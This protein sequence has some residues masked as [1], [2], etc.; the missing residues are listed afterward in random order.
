MKSQLKRDQAVRLVRQATEL[1]L[2]WL[3]DNGAKLLRSSI[4]IVQTGDSLDAGSQVDW[5]K[6]PHLVD[7]LSDH[8]LSSSFQEVAGQPGHRRNSSSDEMAGPAGFEFF[9]RASNAPIFSQHSMQEK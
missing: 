5:V 3:P 4:N 6:H 9:R 8:L 7:R 2:T 1:L